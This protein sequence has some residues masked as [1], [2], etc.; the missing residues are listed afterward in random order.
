MRR[1]RAELAEVK[2]VAS[3]K[4]DLAALDRYKDNGVATLSELQREFRSL[5]HSIIEAEAAPAMR[6]GRIACWLAPSRSCACAA[7]IGLPTTTAS[8]R[9]WRAWSRL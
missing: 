6:T 4:L 2:R 5:A 8:R 3:T 1:S 7:P 9:W